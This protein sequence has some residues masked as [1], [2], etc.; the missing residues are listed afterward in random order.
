MKLLR[1][2]KIASEILADIKSKIRQQNLKPCL[3]VILVGENKASKLYVELKVRAARKIRMALVLHKFKAGVKEKDIINLIKSL[4][5]DKKINGIIVQLPLPKKYHAQKII[6]AISSQKDADGFSAFGGHPS[7]NFV[8]PLP[9]FPTAIM[10]LLESTRINL[11]NKK[12]VIV[13]NS[14]IFGKVMKSTLAR[15]E[16]RAKCALVKDLF[17]L[18]RPS[19]TFSQREKRI[20]SK[21]KNADIIITAVGKPKIIKGGMIKRGVVIIDG[22]ITKRGKK[23]LGD[24]DFNSV[25]RYAGYLSPV[26]GGVGPVTVACLLENVYRLALA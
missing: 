20:M 14:E 22:G 8:E 11:K 16:I 10:K 1:G 13:A 17:P 4:N 6:S 26:P 7:G 19:G 18:I 24:A 2:K 5:K 9:V 23:V 25:A 3:A 21:I 15:K 12:A